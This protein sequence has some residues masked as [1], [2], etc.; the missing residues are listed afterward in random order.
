MGKED[1]ESKIF[2]FLFNY[3][4]KAM[5]LVFP[6]G[7]PAHESLL[8]SSVGADPLASSDE[9]VETFRSLHRNAM[10]QEPFFMAVAILYK[11]MVPSPDNVA[12]YLVYAYTLFRFLHFLAYACHVQPWRSL[13]FICAMVASLILPIKLLM[14]VL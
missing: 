5:F 7:P 14:E 2:Q 6:L 1:K 8:P 4:F 13:T 3:V 9:A 11:V 12:A 10:E